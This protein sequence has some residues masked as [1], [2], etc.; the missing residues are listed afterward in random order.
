MTVLGFLLL[1]NLIFDLMRL[2]IRFLILSDS[3]SKN[4]MRRVALPI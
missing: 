2:L 3:G 4:C 1:L